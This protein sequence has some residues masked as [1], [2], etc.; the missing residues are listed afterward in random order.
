MPEDDFDG[1]HSSLLYAL[2][3]QAAG[4]RADTPMVD[5]DLWTEPGFGPTTPFPDDPVDSK[6]NFHRPI[7]EDREF[8]TGSHRPAT[9]LAL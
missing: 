6:S 3:P 9:A 8:P 2:R 5:L 1:S 7:Y 4:R